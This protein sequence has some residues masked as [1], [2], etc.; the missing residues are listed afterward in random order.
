MKKREAK[1]NKEELRLKIKELGMSKSQFARLVGVDYTTV[2]KWLKGQVP[3]PKYAE[4]CLGIMSERC[5]TCKRLY[6]LK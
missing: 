4:V 2:F 6:E 5:P 3:V 1:I